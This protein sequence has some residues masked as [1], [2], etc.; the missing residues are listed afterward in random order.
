MKSKFILLS[1]ITTLIPHSAH[2]NKSSDYAVKTFKYWVVACN[3]QRVCS[4]SSLL[5]P[6]DD[7]CRG[8]INFLN[9]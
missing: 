2:A 7:E 9:S 5:A 6:A 1:V 4:A 8:N 3:N